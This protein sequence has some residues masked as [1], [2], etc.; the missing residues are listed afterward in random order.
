ML[1][2]PAAVQGLPEAQEEK[3]IKA[4]GEGYNL[5]CCRQPE[6]SAKFEMFYFK[7]LFDISISGQRGWMA[8]EPASL[9]GVPA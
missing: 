9:G 8:N 6:I 5:T 3:E 4:G 7:P 2:A 1:Q